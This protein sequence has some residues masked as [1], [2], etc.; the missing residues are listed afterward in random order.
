MGALARFLI[1]NTLEQVESVFGNS[2]DPTIKAEYAAFVRRME[3]LKTADYSEIFFNVLAALHRLY[4]TQPIVL[5]DEYDAIQNEVAKSITVQGAKKLNMI[6]Q[7][8]GMMSQVFSTLL[9]VQ[10]LSLHSTHNC[11]KTVSLE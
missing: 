4:G 2:E 5:I 11:L 10:V 6:E 7:I 9:K 1:E 3:L 8:D